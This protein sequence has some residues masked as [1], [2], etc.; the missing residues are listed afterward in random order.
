MVRQ[1][2]VLRKISYH[3]AIEVKRWEPVTVSI[4]TETKSS[5]HDRW[6]VASIVGPFTEAIG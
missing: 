4:N 5:T 1:V 3:S 6:I 2:S